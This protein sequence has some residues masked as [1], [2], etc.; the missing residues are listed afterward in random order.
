MP[1]CVSLGVDSSAM[2]QVLMELLPV[3]QQFALEWVQK[4]VRRL[5]PFR[6]L[7]KNEMKYQISKFG[8]DPTKVTIWGVSAGKKF[9]H[10]VFVHSLTLHISHQ[11]PDLCCSM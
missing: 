6:R 2:L 4:H 8:G 1:A 7:Y 5:W 10:V 9:V 11:E 3:D